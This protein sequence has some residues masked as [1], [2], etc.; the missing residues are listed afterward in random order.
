MW[1]DQL[2][3]DRLWVVQMPEDRGDNLSEVWL[4][5]SVD[6]G[7]ETVQ[8]DSVFHSLLLEGIDHATHKANLEMF[9]GV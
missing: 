2:T 7:A 8:H 3:A 9:V 1:S 4:A 5:E 6:D